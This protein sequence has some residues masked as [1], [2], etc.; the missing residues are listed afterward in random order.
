MAEASWFTL[1]LWKGDLLKRLMM[2]LLL[3]SGGGSGGFGLR[4]RLLGISFE[5]RALLLG[6]R[7][8][9]DLLDLMAL[10]TRPQDLTYLEVRVTQGLDR[11]RKGIQIVIL[12]IL[13]ALFSGTIRMTSTTLQ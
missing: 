13:K 10:R 7:P 8:G 12:S 11:E 1:S 2:L 3:V 4:G 6:Q 9:L 5:L